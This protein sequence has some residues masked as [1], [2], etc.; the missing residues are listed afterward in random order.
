MHSVLSN[1]QVSGILLSVKW[2][3]ANP[4]STTDPSSPGEP[5]WNIL[6]D[7]FAAANSFSKG[8]QLAVTPGFN[9]PSW[10]IYNMESCDGLFM[11]ALPQFEFWAPIPRPSAD[12]D[13][14][15]I[16]QETQ[17][18][19]GNPSQKPFP[20]PWSAYYKDA[21][22]GFITALANRYV[23]NPSFVSITVGGPTSSSNEMMLPNNVLSPD[24]LT[25]PSSVPMPPWAT[26]VSIMTNDAWQ[27]LL[28]N[29]YTVSSLDPVNYAA[30]DQ[31]F[32]DEW[33]AAIDFFESTFTGL[34]IGVTNASHMLP[35]FEYGGS[36]APGWEGECP[37]TPPEMACAA[38]TQIYAHLAAVATTGSSGNGTMVEMDA[39][40][41]S[42]STGPASILWVSQATATGYSTLGST[43]VSRVLGGLQNSGFVNRQPLFQGCDESPELALYNDFATA[44]NTTAAGDYYGQTKGVAPLNYIQIWDDDLNYAT[45]HSSGKVLLV[46]GDGSTKNLSF[47]DILGTA[48]QQLLTQTGESVTPPSLPGFP[49]PLPPPRVPFPLPVPPPKPSCL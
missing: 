28:A 7:A 31:A 44:F 35:D 22:R 41:A 17:G 26:S 43:R 18:Q 14:T 39:L 38:M 23:T 5:R 36:V 4:T 15:T 47:L 12:C 13:Y 6:D 10:V 45:A 42:W 3:F 21:Y 20:L 32:I 27:W 29:H 19:G 48:N 33:N 49:F 25:L 2:D 34:T 11:Q 1:D 8:V 16:F 24:P 37:A 46:L 9:T 40:R 30:T